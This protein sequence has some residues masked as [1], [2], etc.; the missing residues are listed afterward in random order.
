MRGGIRVA[1]RSSGH[2]GTAAGG[3]PAAGG[4][5]ELPVQSNARTCYI[6]SAD[7]AG[8]KLIARHM[9]E[10]GA[11]RMLLL[12]PKRDWA[13]MV[14]RK[15]GIK[16]ALRESKSGATLDILRIDGL[17]VREVGDALHRHLQS[18]ELPD[19]ILSGND[20][21]AAASL[22]YMRNLGITVPDEI[23]M[24]GF[25]GNEIT[26]YVEPTLTSVRIPTYEMGQMAGQQIL[27][28][29]A[30]GTF[31]VRDIV[32]PVELVRGEST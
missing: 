4:I 5:Y 31:S 17:S 16:A 29:I 30:H 22:K 6:R 8:G 26:Q 3:A 1:A 15:M 9:L 23:R 11:R 14:Q 21:L 19:A 18:N 25:G 12:L 7:R 13:P 2:P 32:L 24:A 10:Q 20:L 27:G 28:A